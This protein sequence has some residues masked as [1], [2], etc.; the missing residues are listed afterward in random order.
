MDSSND[1]MLSSPESKSLSGVLKSK[2]VAFKI[3]SAIS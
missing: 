2:I 1:S 3:L